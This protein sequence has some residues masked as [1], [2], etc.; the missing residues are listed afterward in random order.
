MVAEPMRKDC[1][2]I[3]GIVTFGK[4]RGPLA[5]FDDAIDLRVRQLGNIPRP[6]A[7]LLSA[8]HHPPRV[9]NV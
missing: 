4:G 7:A 1:D 6:L 9:F 8:P 2:I 5:L 3:L